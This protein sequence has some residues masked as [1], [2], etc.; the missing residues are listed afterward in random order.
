MKNDA[1][2]LKEEQ[3]ILKRL[4]KTIKKKEKTRR[5]VAIRVNIPI[6]TMNSYFFRKVVP[7]VVIL[8]RMADAL[9]VDIKCIIYGEIEN[10]QTEGNRS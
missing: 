1:E 3:E 7:P 6:S 9:H 4:D 10:K 2:Y 5:W 8:K